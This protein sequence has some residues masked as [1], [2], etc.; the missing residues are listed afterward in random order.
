VS[1]VPHSPYQIAGPGNK[2]TASSRAQSATM[3]LDTP[4]IQ[5]ATLV[6]T[7]T[8]P[9]PGKLLISEHFLTVPLAHRDPDGRRVRLF[10]R[11]AEPLET[12]LSPTIEPRHLPLLTYIQ[13]GP[14]F[15]ISHPKDMPCT[16]TLLTKGYKLIC[17]DHRGMG[18]SNT[19]TKSTLARE[20]NAEAQAEYLTH[21]R[22][23]YAVQDL[24]AVRLCLVKHWGYPE[25]KRKWSIMGQSYGGFVCTTYLSMYPEGL[26]EVLI[27]GGL[28]PVLQRS[29]DETV[30]RCVVKLRERNEKFYEK[31]PGDVEGCKKVVDYLRKSSVKL[32]DGGLL[33]PERWLELGIILGMHGGLDSVHENVVRAVNDLETFGE[34][35]RPTLEGA[36]TYLGFDGAILYAL[37]H[38]A[39]Y[40]QGQHSNWAFDRVIQKEQG[41]GTQEPRSRYLFTGEM[42]FSRA[43]DDYSELHGLRDVAN[44]LHA[45]SD[46]DDLYD[47]ERLQQNHVPVYAAVF[48]ED[49]Y[50][51]MDLSLSTASIIKSCKTFVTNQLYHNAVRS[52]SEEVL[53]ALFALRDDTID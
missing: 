36:S 15:G 3:P 42:V 31:F 27:F 43:Y 14:G 2:A 26:R 5:P 45:K 40:C 12:P 33:T 50:V 6:S 11:T 7:T 32:P 38:E 52:K 49:L 9:V 4:S 53:K 10:C 51:P 39:L 8:Y 48:T 22:A 44:I 34:L 16:S 19:V 30:K 20:G 24:E 18:L 29:P 46:W 41:F 37:I 1:G 35:T 13:G 28:P 17:V 25:E 23:P 47:V 21:F